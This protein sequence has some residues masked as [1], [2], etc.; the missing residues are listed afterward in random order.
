MTA[1]SWLVR[2][3]SA[4]A[5]RC[6]RLT[7]TSVVRAP[8]ASEATAFSYTTRCFS[9]PD[10]GPRQ[11]LP[12]VLLSRN[13]FHAP[14]SDNKR[15]VCPVGAVSKRT[16]SKSVV[17]SGWP[18]S[19]ENS[20]KAAISIVQAPESCSSMPRTM[21]SG[22]LPRYGPTSFSRYAIA[23]AAGSM[24]NA[25]SRGT[26]A[27]AVG[28]EVRLTPS[29][30]SRLEAGSVL[31]SNTRLPLSASAMAE[32]HASEVLPTPPLPV[33]NRKR[34]GASKKRASDCSG[35]MFISAR[36]ATAAAIRLRGC[37]RCR[38]FQLEPARQFGAVGVTA[39]RRHFAV[40][41]NHRQRAFTFFRQRGLHQF[42]FHKRRRVLRE[43][44][45][46]DNHV[47]RFQ[48]VEI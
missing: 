42:V 26:L 7:R 19:L 16:W 43:V 18:S 3:A 28:V 24:F 46:L 6:A 44:V 20:S 23:A 11:E 41:Q 33:K 21:A 40:E 39:R 12:V 14:G 27:I 38:G 22:S 36:S 2:S 9:K 37:R 35:A 48:P 15:S 31:T 10:S 47:V 30:S 45:P 32:A 4:S 34:V 17:A 1:N 8:S 13:P 25:A 29:T 5:A